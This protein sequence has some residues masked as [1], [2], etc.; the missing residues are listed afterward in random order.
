MRRAL[1][2]IVML[3]LAGVLLAACEHDKEEEGPL[4]A[5]GVAPAALAGSTNLPAGFPQ[6]S[7]V[8]YTGTMAEG[9]STVV[10]GYA[11]GDLDA[12]FGAY[13]TALGS[14]AFKVTKDEKDPRDAEVNFAGRGQ[15]GQ[16]KLSE[17]CSGRVGVT[18][19]V[20]PS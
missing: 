13:R 8:T 3:S 16:V 14:S 2:V 19:T 11:K 12:A 10:S 9:P 1:S 6:P 20:R 7:S 15:S 4:K 5:C 17:T 18:I